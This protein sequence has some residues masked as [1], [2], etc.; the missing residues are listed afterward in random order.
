MSDVFTER[1]LY[2]QAL[3]RLHND[4]LLRYRAEVTAHA[5]RRLRCDDKLKAPGHL[6]EED[7]FIAAAALIAA[8]LIPG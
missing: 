2:Q 8:E 5:L 3:H 6:L 4:A 7:R 1:D